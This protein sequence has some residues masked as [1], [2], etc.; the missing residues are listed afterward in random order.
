MTVSPM[1]TC[2]PGRR[3]SR[4][5]WQSAPT[6][7]RCGSQAAAGRPPSPAPWPTR[8][9]TPGAIADTGI[10][11]R[12]PSPPTLGG[13]LK[14]DRGWEG[15]GVSRLPSVAVHWLPSPRRQ[16]PRTNT[17]TG[18]R[19][20]P[21]PVGPGTGNTPRRNP[22][23][24]ARRGRGPRAPLLLRAAYSRAARTAGTTRGNRTRK[25]SAPHHR[26]TPSRWAPLLP[27]PLNC[28]GGGLVCGAWRPGV[29]QLT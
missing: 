29:L 7:P 12:F 2:P 20:R 5:Q 22:S 11:H 28:R 27:Q 26:R 14:H 23:S 24:A 9:P 1:A 8:R 4:W 6:V 10:W 17:P 13:G 18:R 25:S 21:R 15:K 16:R 3:S 19:Q